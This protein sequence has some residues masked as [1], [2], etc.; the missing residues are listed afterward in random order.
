MKSFPFS[1]RKRLVVFTLSWSI[2]SALGFSGCNFPP[3]QDKGPS[4][5]SVTP[6][7]IA[8]T[9]P[10]NPLAPPYP[11]PV[12]DRIDG[13]VS[14][15]DGTSLSGVLDAEV[16][17]LDST[18]NDLRARTI[19]IAC[20]TDIGYFVFRNSPDLPLAAGDYTLEVLTGL[21]ESP[22]L[23]GATPLEDPDGVQTVNTAVVSHP[24]AYYVDFVYGP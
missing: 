9:C 18:T 5:A 8:G 15:N 19:T 17:L 7:A 16:R 20:G 1:G 13:F 4:G 12:P 21:G 22:S 6:T 2:A 10:A 11:G 14:Y 24:G 23:V 3:S